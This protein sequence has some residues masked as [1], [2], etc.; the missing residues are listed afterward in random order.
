[1]RDVPRKRDGR[2]SRSVERLVATRDP[3][4]ALQ[5]EKM[6]VLTL[7]NMHRRAV[8][9]KRMYLDNR[10]DTL[11]VRGRHPYEATLT[12]PRLQPLALVRCVGSTRVRC[13]CC[14]ALSSSC[15]PSSC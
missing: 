3:R 11:R 5:D 8:T 7:M 12:R 2:T 1:M 4:G 13:H 6:L 10:I 15:V 9:R 14:G